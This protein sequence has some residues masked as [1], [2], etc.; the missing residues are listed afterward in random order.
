MLPTVSILNTTAVASGGIH[1]HVW[2]FLAIAAVALFALGI[3]LI[4]RDED[5]ADIVAVVMGIV[6][7]IL[8]VVTAITANIVYYPTALVHI[9]NSTTSANTTIVNQV[10]IVPVFQY[11]G[12]SQLSYLFYLLVVLDVLLIAYGWWSYASR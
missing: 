2:I 3:Y 5:I 7:V 12:L 8:A 4:T 6:S 9:L 1:Y 10:V 11:L